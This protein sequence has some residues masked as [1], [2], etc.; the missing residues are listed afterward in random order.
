MP[1][2]HTRIKRRIRASEMGGRNR[3][4]RPKTFKSEQA[5]KDYAKKAGIENY[6]LENIKSSEAKVKKIRIVPA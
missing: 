3:G 1:K 5:A 4:S 2:I 6:K